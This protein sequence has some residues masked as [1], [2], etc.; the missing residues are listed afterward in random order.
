MGGFAARKALNIIEHVE[1]G[2]VDRA[3]DRQLINCPVLAMELLAACQGLEFLKPLRTT[4]PLHKVYELVRTVS[5]YVFYEY[6][7]CL[8]DG[9]PLQ[10]DESRSIRASGD[11]GGHPA[12]TREQGWIDERITVGYRNRAGVGVCCTASVYVP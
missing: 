10:S 12:R 2:T 3:R 1:A 6:A 7:S 4:A 8:V 11:R 9:L 5:P